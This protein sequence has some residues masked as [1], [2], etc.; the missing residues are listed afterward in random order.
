VV[1]AAIHSKFEMPK[2]E[3]TSRIAKAFKNKNVDIFAHPTG[4][5]LKEREPYA[6]DINEI[7]KVAGDYGVAMELNAYP[8]RLDL[9]DIHCK[10]AKAM[11]VKIAVGSDSHSAKQLDNMRWG[12]YT[13]RRGWLEKKD[14][15]NI[16]PVEKLLKIFKKL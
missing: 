16:L 1:A 3:M 15:L 9:N 14:V 11:G 5:L 13:A 6:V 12:V 10:L 2:P 4:R 8:D 7:F